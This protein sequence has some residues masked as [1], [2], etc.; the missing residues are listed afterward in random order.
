MKMEHEAKLNRT[1]ICKIR[2]KCGFTVKER[3]KT[4]ELTELLGSELASLV[5]SEGRLRQFS[6]TWNVKTKLTASDSVQ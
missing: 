6:D 1:E 4:A 5:P 2:R 3:H